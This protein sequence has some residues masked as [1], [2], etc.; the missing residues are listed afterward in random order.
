MIKTVMLMILDG[1]G[2][3]PETEGNA[4]KQANMSYYNRLLEEYPN[5]IIITS[6]EEVG[7]PA[8]QMGNSEVGHTNIG[9]RKNCLSRFVKNKQGNRFW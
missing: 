5:N 4:V 8:G 7:L 1:F 9:A 3:N 6:G 2:I